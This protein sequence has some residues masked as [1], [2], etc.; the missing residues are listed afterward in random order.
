MYL[1]FVELFNRY[2]FTQYFHYK[3]AKSIRQWKTNSL[4][5]SSL[6]SFPAVTWV[7]FWHSSAFDNGCLAGFSSLLDCSSRDPIHLLQSS[8]VL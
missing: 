3:E 6:S 8:F 1:S 5:T 2:Y 4:E 7:D